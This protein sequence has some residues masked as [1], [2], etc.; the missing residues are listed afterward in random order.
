MLVITIGR[1]VARF[2]VLLSITI[3][4][5]AQTAP[6]R[7]QAASSAEPRDIVVLSITVINKTGNL[8][9]ALQRDNFRVFIDKQPAEIVEFREVNVPIS[10]GIVFDASG[11]AGYSPSM[12]LVT[13]S[14]QK[15]LSSFRESSNSANEYFLMAFNISPQLLLNWTSDTNAIINS[16]SS[17]EPK[18]N[19]A[20]YDACYVALDKVRHGRYSKRVLLLITDG[21]DNVSKYS[22]SQVRDELKASGVI[23]YSLNFSNGDAAA[24][25]A[26]GQKGQQILTQFSSIS[27]GRDFYKRYGR[28]T[29][30]DA[31]SAF[32][33]IAQ[34]LRQQY[35]IAVRHKIPAGDNKWHKIKIKVEDP[36]EKHLSARTREGFYLD[37]R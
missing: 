26:L 29:T 5:V 28:L 1:V 11:S 10:I 15:A 36:R 25:S 30:A 9:S 24:G 7:P 35:T 3:A 23:V 37:Q 6:E 33:I 27:G 4:G 14:S 17:I 32:N 31:I 2:A 19:T 16:L 34:E 12:G 21:Q 20:F 8:V 22:L 18:Q 13:Q